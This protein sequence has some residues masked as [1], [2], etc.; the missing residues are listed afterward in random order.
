MSCKTPRRKYF[1]LFVE[2]TSFK[3]LS[4]KTPQED[5]DMR[6]FSHALDVRNLMYIQLC[7]SFEK[8]CAESIISQFQSNRGPNYK[9]TVKNP[10]KYFKRMRNYNSKRERGGKIDFFFHNNIT[11]PFTKVQ[12]VRVFRE[13]SRRITNQR[14]QLLTL[15][16]VGDCWKYVLKQDYFINIFSKVTVNVNI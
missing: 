2:F 7:N 14:Q 13:V 1:P 4:P 16:Q 12:C 10:L 9:T 3:E 6:R 5:K 8:Y 15:V 11:D